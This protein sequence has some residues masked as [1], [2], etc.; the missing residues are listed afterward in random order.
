M[1]KP[2]REA[3]VGMVVSSHLPSLIVGKWCKSRSPCHPSDR[4]RV[5]PDMALTPQRC[6]ARLAPRS[7]RKAMLALLGQAE[8]RGA[9][10][11]EEY[12]PSSPEARARR[13]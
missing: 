1:P 7:L 4:R 12:G 5:A 3:G 11:D 6:A 10:T 9:V 2:C 8:L 13:L